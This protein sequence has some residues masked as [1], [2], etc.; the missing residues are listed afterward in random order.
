[1]NI[2]NH[3]PL[4]L[5]QL[6]PLLLSRRHIAGKIWTRGG[7]RDSCG[8]ADKAQKSMNDR[9]RNRL[10]MY[11]ATRTYLDGTEAVWNGIDANVDARDALDAKINEIDAKVT[12]QEAS[13]GGYTQNKYQLRETLNTAILLVS[14]ATAAFARA[15]GNPILL[16]DV[17]LQPS[18]VTGATDQVIDDIA[19][20]VRAAAS[21]NLAP[22]MSYGITALEVT[23]LEDAIA[24]H[25]GAK[26]MPDAMRAERSGHTQTLEPLF[27][28]T[29]EHLEGTLDPLMRRYK[30]SDPQ[31]HAGYEAAR[32]IIN[33][34][35]PGDDEEPEPEPDPGP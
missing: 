4:L 13:L 1:M 20:R 25:E 2:R 23:A 21:A 3:C 18:D 24:D 34:S 11:K 5:S 22:L 33:L 16:A 6:N 7:K 29:T 35:G 27:K 31:F 10:R 30:P 8:I 12:A 17:D 19:E 15:T 26:S 28:S 32:V 14:G 9:Q